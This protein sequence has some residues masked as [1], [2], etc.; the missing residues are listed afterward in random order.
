MPIKIPKQLPAKDILENEN[1]FVMDEDRAQSQDIRPLNILIVNL[2][3]EKEKAEAQ[4]LRL[5]GNTPL[6]VNITFLRMQTHESKNTSKYHLDQFY[7]TFEEVKH[8]KFDGMIITGAPVEKLNFT[9]V[10]YWKE[11]SEIMNWSNDHVTSTLHICWGAQAALYHHY[12]IDKFELPKKCSGVY[13]HQLLYRDEKLVRGFDDYFIAPHSRYTDVSL[14]AIQNHP[15]LL[16]LAASDQ[17]GV[18]LICSK[19]GKRIMITGHPEYEADTLKQEYTRDVAKG[20][21]I[22]VPDNY[23]PNNDPDK[24]PPHRWRSHSNL[25]FS[26]WLNYYVYQQ[27]PY[28]WS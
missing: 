3:P 6:Q 12:Q 10:N 21:D 27:T 16:V 7:S 8:R 20:L 11:L 24:E 19:D 13:E 2:M 25:L 5:L 9:D 26:N 28:Q 23:F 14:E 4:L 18:Y 17:A 1:I 22:H 15:D